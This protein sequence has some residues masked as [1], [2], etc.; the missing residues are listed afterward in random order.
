MSTMTKMTRRKHE[1]EFDD[2]D[3]D[4]DFDEID[5]DVDSDDVD[6]KDK[7][8]FWKSFWMSFWDA[9]SSFFST[10]LNEKWVLKNDE[11][12]MTTNLINV[13]LTK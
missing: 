8:L 2:V 11:Q 6:S 12:N 1:I 5:S 9:R 4:I 13:C 10:L 3:F 7:I